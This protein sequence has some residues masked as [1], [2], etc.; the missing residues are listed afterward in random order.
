MTGRLASNALAASY[1]GSERGGDR[2]IVFLFSGQG[3]Q[4]YQMGMDLYESDM[5]FR[6]HV[7]TLDVM[8]RDVLGYSVLNLIGDSRRKPSEPFIDV[9]TSSVAIYVVER[10]LTR[11]LSDHGLEPAICVASSM[12]LY[13]SLTAAGC[14]DEEVALKFVFAQGRAFTETC[15]PGGMISILGD[16]A[17]HQSVPELQRTTDLAGINFN[18]AFVVSAPANDLPALRELLKSR[19][20]AYQD[21][22]V[23]RAFHSRWIAPAKDRIDVLAAPLSGRRLR[24]PLACCTKRDFVEQLEPA[25]V[26]NALR[27]PIM[28]RDT[29]LRLEASGPCHYVD[30]GP[31]GTMATMLKYVLP[32]GGGSTSHSILSPFGQGGK[33]LSALLTAL[34]EAGTA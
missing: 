9:P 12:G 21:L 15:E 13:A 32:A 1:P 30:V 17:L 20:L 22:P 26:W 2:P 4:Y 28:F 25:T 3:S 27:S 31:S 19:K 14:L 29:I 6:H 23:A 16:P 5:R 10:A 24:I 34:R 7:E 11:C 33:R 18:D 8:A